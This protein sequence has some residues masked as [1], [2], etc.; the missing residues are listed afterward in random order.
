[1]VTN[2]DER[3]FTCEIIRESIFHHYK[4][5]IPYS[6]EVEIDTFKDKSPT[7][8]V[9]EANILVSR[10]SQKNIVIGKGGSMLKK[11]GTYAR[12]KLEEFLDRKVF[13][14]LRVKVDEDWRS[15]EDSLVK[16]GYK[17]SDM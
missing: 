13:L 10:D 5:E 2:R 7:L 17:D 4:D 6:C 8:S 11:V 15:N 1:M 9:I 16:Y 3:F 14:S 12:G